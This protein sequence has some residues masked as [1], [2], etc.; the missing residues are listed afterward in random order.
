[1]A[2]LTEQE[3]ITL[4]EIGYD[5]SF[6]P[7]FDDMRSELFDFLAMLMKFN[8]GLFSM[9]NIKK[10][11]V[12]IYNTKGFDLDNR[13]ISVC[14]E[15]MQN[16]GRIKL[17]AS[18]TEPVSIETDIS[19]I[20]NAKENDLLMKF[21]K[22]L[23]LEHSLSICF[24]Y[25]NE[26]VG[27]MQLLRTGGEEPFSKREIFVLEQ[28]YKHIAYR[29][30]YESKKSDTRYFYDRA[31][32]DQLKAQYGF[33]DR[34]IE[35]FEYAVRGLNNIQIAE[36]ANISVSTVKKHFHNIYDKMGV[37]GRVELLNALPHS[38]SKINFDQFNGKGG[39]QYGIS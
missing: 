33:T 10:R 30:N 34:E 12:T 18:R 28:L 15:G 39:G 17:L 13:Y 23:N 1:M 32:I 7:D 9:L 21:Y 35:L 20:R 4:N 24:A 26:P 27:F 22:P 5:I 37:S 6:I 19:S 11:E 8:Y 31:Y 29:L 38:Y 16:E 14:E 36:Q 3:W 25:K 2:Y